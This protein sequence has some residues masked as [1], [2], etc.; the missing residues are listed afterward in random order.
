M[1]TT[2]ALAMWSGNSLPGVRN[3]MRQEE[4]QITIVSTD[5]VVEDTVILINKTTQPLHIKQF[6]PGAVVFSN[7]LVKLNDL[8]QSD[9]DLVLQPERPFAAPV[10]IWHL[11][12]L[13]DSGFEYIWA[14]EAVSPL[15][16]NTD[17]VTL[18]GY[19]TEQQAVLF[20]VSAGGTHA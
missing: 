18:G 8:C 14:N 10:K 20:P 11:L 17:I 9:K 15:S 4:L 1:L 2:P 3:S 7:K 6:R 5:A 19:V 16:E 13:A 12:T